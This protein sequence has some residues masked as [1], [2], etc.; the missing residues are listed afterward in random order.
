MEKTPGKEVES[1]KHYSEGVTLYSFWAFF[2]P[3]VCVSFVT[4]AEGMLT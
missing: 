1:L 2:V 4:V 3:F